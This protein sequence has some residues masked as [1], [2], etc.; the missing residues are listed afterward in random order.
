MPGF[1]WYFEEKAAAAPGDLVVPVPPRF[2]SAQGHVIVAR[3]EA[4]ALVAYLLSLRQPELQ[5]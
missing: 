4:R 3:P 5:R 2:V 1:P